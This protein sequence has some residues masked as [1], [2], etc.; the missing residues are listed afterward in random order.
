M[1]Y[2]PELRSKPTRY[3]DDDIGLITVKLN[4]E[5]VIMEMETILNHYYR[6]R[7]EGGNIAW[8]VL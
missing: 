7:I 2:V 3:I 8:P 1:F 4:I 5:N 6:R